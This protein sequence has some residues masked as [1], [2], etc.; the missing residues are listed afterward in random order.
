M[1]V[2]ILSQFPSPAVQSGPAIHTR[3]LRQGLER[4]GHRVVMMGPDTGKVA[5]VEGDTDFLFP[6]FAYATH[7]NV[8]VSMPGRPG[9]LFMDR[10][11]VD[12]IHGQANCHMKHY[13]VWAREMWGIPFLNTHIIHLP[14]HSHFLLSDKLFANDTVR[15]WW[16]ARAVDME[17]YFATHIYNKS[18]CFIVQSKHMV[19]YWRERGVTT[20]IEV[21]GRPIN[22]DI[23]SRPASSDPY[24]HTL[25]KGHRLLVVCRHDREKNLHELIELFARHIAPA[26]PRASLTLVGDGH[27]HL[28]LV[29]QAMQTPYAG[30]I[31]FPGE[32]DHKV[33]T[34]WYGHADLFVYTSVS[35]TFGNVVN[36]ALW[37]GLPV[38]AYDDGMG[39]AGQ[40]SDGVNGL[41]VPYHGITD[42]DLRFAR[43]TLSLLDDPERR[44]A[45]RFE[46]RRMA[47]GTAH[48]DVVL[49]RFE[50]IYR[51]AELHRKE[52]LP[53][54][55][56]KQ[57]RLAQ[58]RAFARHYAAWAWWNGALITLGHTAKGLGASR[59]GGA[60]Q[61]AAA[62]RMVAATST[63]SRPITARVARPTAA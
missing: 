52:T 2:G 32:V 1:K 38:V 26:N 31:F 8:K 44:A 12:V 48:P 47:R 22:P 13:G 53:V 41:L 51:D 45:M 14:T 62:E 15:E 58:M 57:G 25:A 61:H 39:V 4:R 50:Q 46:A 23:F 16:R 33:L 43:A 18:D 20:P 19:G 49:S 5:P 40:M 29:E 55:L 37:T 3:F 54:P 34:D 60:E 59:T 56:E 42:A 10:P 30:R 27:D 28:N 11:D 63:S 7:P 35:E 36:E 17:R 6:S 21:V 24:P 9:H